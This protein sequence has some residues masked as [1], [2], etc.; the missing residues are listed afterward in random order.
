[1]AHAVSANMSSPVC[2]RRSAESGVRAMSVQQAADGQP[3]RAEVH[4]HT[5]HRVGRIDE[6]IFSG[7]LEHMGRAVYE[8]VYDPGNPLSD[9]QG[10]RTD[11]LDACGDS[12]GCRWS[13]TRAA[14]LFPTMTGATRLALG[15][16]GP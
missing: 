16:S 3:N 8:G 9:E 7:F 14:T 12:C 2:V 1:M 13:A 10:F 5:E 4:L 11:V 15:T 6:R